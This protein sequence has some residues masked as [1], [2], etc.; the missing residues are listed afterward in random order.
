M[1]ARRD[2]QRAETRLTELVDDVADMCRRVLQNGPEPSYADEKLG[3]ALRQ[4]ATALVII[5]WTRNQ[6]RDI[7]TE[8]AES[9][10][11]RW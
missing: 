10:S 8:A 7:A 4:L 2:R 3:F 1:T 11:Q 6:I 9:E 5:G